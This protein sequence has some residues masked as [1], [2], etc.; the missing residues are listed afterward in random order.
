[1]HLHESIEDYKEG[2]YTTP[3]KNEREVI[4]DYFPSQSF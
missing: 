1:M 2:D 4:L 3:T